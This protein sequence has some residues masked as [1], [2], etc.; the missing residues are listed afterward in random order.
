MSDKKGC[1]Y[2]NKSKSLHY[3]KCNIIQEVYIEADKTL[4]VTHYVSEYSISID[5]DYC[6]KCGTKLK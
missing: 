2:C 5:I 1:E 6:P 3:D 4:S